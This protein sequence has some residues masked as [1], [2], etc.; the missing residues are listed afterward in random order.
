MRGIVGSGDPQ[1]AKVIQPQLGAERDRHC[2]LSDEPRN[3]EA[4]LRPGIDELAIAHP[5]R[6]DRRV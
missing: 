2:T 5:S 1:S 4:R 3:E 6:G